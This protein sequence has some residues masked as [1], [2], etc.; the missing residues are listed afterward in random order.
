MRYSN[1][2]VL[3]FPERFKI[4]IQEFRTQ[5][6][7]IG[8]KGMAFT[9]NSWLNWTNNLTMNVPDSPYLNTP[10]F[11]SQLFY[12]QRSL[13]QLP[14]VTCFI[15]SLPAQ[16]PFRVSIHSW[17]KPQPSR[18]LESLMHPDDCVLYEVRIYTDNVCVACVFT[19]TSTAVLFVF[20]LI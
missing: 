13:G 11:N 18:I 5:C 19:I 3:L 16:S 15:P 9:Q 10:Y 6:C 2:D 7:V 4:P 20:C 1:W 12:S 14:V 8:D 17:E